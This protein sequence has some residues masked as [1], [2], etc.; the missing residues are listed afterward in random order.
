MR[1]DQ[2][3]RMRDELRA[4]V[5]GGARPDDDVLVEGLK[6]SPW[7]ARLFL[8]TYYAHDHDERPDWLTQPEQLQLPSPKKRRRYAPKK[9]P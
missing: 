8:L 7:L 4:D 1:G 3:I 6:S 9:K 2:G 5:P